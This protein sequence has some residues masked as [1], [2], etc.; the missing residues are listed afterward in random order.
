MQPARSVSQPPGG[1]SRDD[2]AHALLL[3][4]GGLELPLLG[5]RGG[6]A[7][8]AHEPRCRWRRGFSR[9]AVSQQL[10]QLLAHGGRTLPSSRQHRGRAL[11]TYAP[12]SAPDSPS[13]CS[14]TAAAAASRT[15]AA[16][17]AAAAMVRA[18]EAPAVTGS[19]AA[20]CRPVERDR[21]GGGGEGGCEEVRWM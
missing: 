4:L 13:R 5:C 17:A 10:Q 9:Q 2:L 11:V 19:S 16:A 20:T 18:S 3:G 15:T 8:E 6:P 1:R 21:F 14:A 12:S 7:V